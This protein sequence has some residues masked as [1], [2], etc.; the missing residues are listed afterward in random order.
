MNY[1]NISMFV[2]S[3]LE[4]PTID[5]H[6]IF[7]LLRGERKRT[8]NISPL[9]MNSSRNSFILFELLKSGKC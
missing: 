7:T 4:A 8:I 9:S 3:Y 5:A 2:G 1:C 6:S